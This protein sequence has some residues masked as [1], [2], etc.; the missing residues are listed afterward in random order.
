MKISEL[1]LYTRTHA[2]ESFREYRPEESIIGL[3]PLMSGGEAV[4]YNP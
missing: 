4:A 1:D 3:M 2:V